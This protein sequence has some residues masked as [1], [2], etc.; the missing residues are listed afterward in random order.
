MK[1]LLFDLDNT[2]IPSDEAYLAALSTVG[3]AQGDEGR[4]QD[5]RALVKAA[6][7]KGHV[8]ARNRLLYFKAMLKS[9]K[10]FS[11]SKILDLMTS[12]EAA[13][14]SFLQEWVK[15]SGRIA[16]VER[17]LGFADGCILTN[18]NLRTQL[19]KVRA[20]G[21]AGQK[22]QGMVT[23][24]E[25]GYEKPRLQIFQ[26]ALR[27]FNLDPA[28]VIMVGDDLEN[29]ILPALKLGMTCVL[30][31]EF[32]KTSAHV[33]DGVLRISHLSELESLLK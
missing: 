23:S 24:E 18:E 15:A 16:V 19:I 33:P 11:A 3:V 13:L 17:L 4:F 7:P 31:E 26:H 28:E 30:T 10:P 32:I 14:E 25:V 29:D 5:A 27:T 20:L 12:Y 2:L 8:A 21:T 9:E 22:F 1:F 6:L